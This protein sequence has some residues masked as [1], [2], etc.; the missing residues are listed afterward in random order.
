MV[1]SVTVRLP[2]TATALA[3]TPP[4]PA[5][6]KDFAT[7][8]VSFV[9]TPTPVRVSMIRAGVTAV[10]VAPARSACFSWTT[11]VVQSPFAAE[12]SSA[13]HTASGSTGSMATPT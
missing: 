8:L 6:W 4:C 11:W 9:E 7:P 10:Y 13:V 3:G 5:T 1:W 2:V 12:T